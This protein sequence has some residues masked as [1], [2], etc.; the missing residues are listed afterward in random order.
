MSDLQKEFE[1]LEENCKKIDNYF[2]TDSECLEYCESKINS[3]SE[4][5]NTLERDFNIFSDVIKG[6]DTYYGCFKEYVGSIFGNFKIFVLFEIFVYLISFVVVFSLEN[7]IFRIIFIGMLF[8]VTIYNYIIVRRI[9]KIKNDIR[10]EIYNKYDIDLTTMDEEEIEELDL[11]SL[12]NRIRINK[13]DDEIIK[14]RFY[15]RWKRSKM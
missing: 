3:L 8:V 11:K 1:M 4:E 12:R 6:Y 14:Y 7:L 15:I 5:V 13:I 9:S 10:N 2:D